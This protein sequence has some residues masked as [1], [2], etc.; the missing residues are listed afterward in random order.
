MNYLLA[1]TFLTDVSAVVL[2]M[3]V[4]LAEC[5]CVLLLLVPVAQ[6]S[7]FQQLHLSA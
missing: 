7:A 5:S 6:S 4:E 2:P 3:L 1:P